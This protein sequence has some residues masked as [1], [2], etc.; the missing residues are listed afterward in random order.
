MS[1][2]CGVELKSSEA[3]LA[4]IACEDGE[5]IVVDLEPRKIG[6]EDDESS[7]AIKSFYDSFNDFVRNNHIETVVVKKRAKKGKMAG[8]AISFKLEALIQLNEITNV[9]FVSGQGIAAA[10][11]RRPFDIP[12]ELKKYQQTAFMAASLYLRQQ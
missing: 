7:A 2:I 10:E 3:I 12:D 11:K 6:I 1:R 5:E 8:G 4:V 9:A